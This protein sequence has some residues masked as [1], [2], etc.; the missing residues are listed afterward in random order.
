MFFIITANSK[1]KKFHTDKRL[2]QF[3]DLCIISLYGNL[4]MLPVSHKPNKTNQFFQ[5]HGHSPHLWWF[6]CNWWLMVTGRSPEVNWGH[7]LFFANNS[8]QDGDRYAQ[9]VPNDMACQVASKDM[10]IDVLRSW[11][12]LDLTLTWRPEAKIWNWPF[13]VIKQMFRT[14]STGQTRCCHFSFHVPH[15][16]KVINEKPYPWKTKTFH[17]MTSGAK[18]VDLRS[19]LN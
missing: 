16:T 17:L 7:T 14:G 10:H 18:T 8:R 4:K 9:M 6:R 12:V 3:R 19:H 2:C 13:K 11:P 5:D 15:I 1:G